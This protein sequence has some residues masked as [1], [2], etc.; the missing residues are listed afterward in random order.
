MRGGG[1]AGEKGPWCAEPRLEE[2]ETSARGILE[3]MRAGEE[4]AG[5]SGRGPG[6]GVA[7]ATESWG[8][9]R[10]REFKPEAGAL[11]RLGCWR[12]Y[13]WGRGSW[14]GAEKKEGSLA[15]VGRLGWRVP[16]LCLLRIP[17]V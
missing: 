17:V 11:L 16:D 15:G 10:S 2:A 4:E 6:E 12:V 9:D 7:G 13:P 14:G 3:R 8:G 1:V 5:S